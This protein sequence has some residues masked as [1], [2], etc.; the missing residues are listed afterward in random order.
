MPA[1]E[2]S[3]YLTFDD[4]PDPETTPRILEI[5]NSYAAKATFFC[6]GENVSDHISTYNLY[7]SQGHTVGNHSYDHPRGWETSTEKYIENVKRCSEVV[8]STL[9]RPPYGKMTRSQRRALRKDFTIIMW[10]VLSRDYDPNIDAEKCL[11]KTWK[12]TRPGAIVLFHDS[13]KTIKKLEY[14][15]PRYLER[16]TDSGYNFKILDAGC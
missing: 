15:L 3:L 8:E 10:T 6:V 14:V 7:L 13:R 9:F 1:D 5:L 12:H 2:K 11:E 16:A 4:G